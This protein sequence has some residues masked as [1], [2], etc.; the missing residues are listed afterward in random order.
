MMWPRN[1]QVRLMLETDFTLDLPDSD[2][3]WELCQFIGRFV[4]D[5][6]FLEIVLN[7]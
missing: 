5:L 1:C 6:L 7:W 2:I 4:P 3:L